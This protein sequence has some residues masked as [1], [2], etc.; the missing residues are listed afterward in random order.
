MTK[1]IGYCLS[2]F[3]LFLFTSSCNVYQTVDK[4]SENAQYLSRARACFDQ[5]QFDCASEYYQKLSDAYQDRGIV[6]DTFAVLEKEGAGMGTFISAFIGGG[7]SG[8]NK[9][10]SILHKDAG[11]SK[12][13]VLFDVYKNHLKIQDGDLRAFIR[14]ITSAVLGAEILGEATGLDNI[15]NLDDIAKDGSACKKKSSTDA[16]FST[17]C[18]VP[19]GIDQLASGTT[20]YDFV[21]LVNCPEAKSNVGMVFAAAIEVSA[22]LQALNVGGKFGTGLGS[23]TSAISGLNAPGTNTAVDRIA[24]NALLNAGFGE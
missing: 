5:G 8:L 22:A 12:R 24:R 4:P 3:I 23:A 19:I 6:E 17:E 2:I 21:T 20:V 1:Q 13:K 7:S 18:D 11:L 14:F 16:P 10:A 15:L 9:L